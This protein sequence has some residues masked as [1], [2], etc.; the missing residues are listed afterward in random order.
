ME[1]VPGASPRGVPAGMR[2]RPLTT[3]TQLLVDMKNAQI[4]VHTEPGRTITAPTWPASFAR[5]ST[6]RALT[7]SLP[8]SNRRLLI[9]RPCA[10]TCSRQLRLRQ[11]NQY[12]PRLRVDAPGRVH[13]A[14]PRGHSL[15]VGPDW[16]EV[17]EASLDF[18]SRFAT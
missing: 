10:N 5:Y 6:S 1:E 11:R 18:I 12:R 9:G 13:T 14:A 16:Q 7:S 3:F 4:P 2:W 15:T 17:A 8:E